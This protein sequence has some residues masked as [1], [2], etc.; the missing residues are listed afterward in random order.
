VA[1]ELPLVKVADADDDANPNVKL[2]ALA[3]GSHCQDR[4][5]SHYVSILSISFLKRFLDSKQTERL[6]EMHSPRC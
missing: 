5:Q 4:Q 3:E 2:A 6:V 1:V